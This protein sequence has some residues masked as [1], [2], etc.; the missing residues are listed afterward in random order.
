MGIKTE[1]I[2]IL[3]SLHPQGSILGAVFFLIYINDLPAI[4]NNDNNM[5]LFEDETSI[6]ITDTNRSDFN[7]NAN[8]TFQDINTW[9]LCL[10]HRASSW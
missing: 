1:V 8:Q 5:A 10:L 4:V 7:I 9:I 6:I 3:Y 2:I